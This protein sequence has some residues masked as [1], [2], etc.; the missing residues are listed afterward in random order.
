MHLH[1]RQGA[2]MESVVPLTAQQFGRAIIMPNTKPFIS[3]VDDAARYRDEILA[4]VPSGVSFEPLMTLYLQTTT[5]PETIR[6][7]KRSGFIHGMK[8]YP[9]GK[10]TNAEGGVNHIS[11]VADQLKVMEEVDLPLLV[12]GESAQE[13]TD[14]F[15]REEIFYATAWIWLLQKFPK[16]RMVAEHITTR[17]AVK[18]V[19]AARSYARVGAT[20]TP[21]HLLVNRG[22]M[23][24]GNLRPHAYCKP[25]LKRE[26]D[27]L[28]L[29]E[30]ATSGSTRFFLGTDSAP[31]PKS[32]AAKQA[33]EAD[34]GC[35]GCFTGHAALEM[36]AEAF[37]S[38]DSLDRLDDFAS[39]FGADFYELPRNEGSVTLTKEEWQAPEAYPF[40]DAEV[41]PFRQEEPLKWKIVA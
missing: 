10:T 35:A 4:A 39:R 36:Y 12:H 20:I 41:V 40:G 18:A 7:A 26:E 16:L 19:L 22:Y 17:A 23:L 32:G 38:K 24:D 5:S 21:Q 3:T 1:V 37:E 13:G 8:L 34:C 33:K 2:R 31:H 27:R 9:A 14:P 30:V 25:I 15:D 28:A 6:A 29:M 11:D